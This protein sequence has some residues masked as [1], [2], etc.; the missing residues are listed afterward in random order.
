MLNIKTFEVNP[1]GENTYIVSD[2][3][4]ECVVI[5][6]G[7]LHESERKA[8]ADYIAEN[9]LIVKHSILTHAHFDHCFGCSFIAEKYGAKPKMHERDC[10]GYS[11]MGTQS[12]SLMGVQIGE[13]YP[14]ADS[15]FTE[16]GII[17]FG[18]HNF[19]IIHTPGHTQGSVFFFCEEEK[20]AFSG[21][22]LF[23]ASIGRTDFEGGSTPDI[24]DSLQNKVSKLPWDTTVYPGHGPSTTIRVEM[25]SNPYLRGG[26]Y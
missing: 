16:H 5:D 4:K 12:K 10:R 13:D 20:V 26:I 21:D 1:L 2:E 18:T 11:K 17:E 7:A 3:T 6:C 8:I 24:L 22:T 19:K 9:N 15:Y 14:E 25:M 23:R